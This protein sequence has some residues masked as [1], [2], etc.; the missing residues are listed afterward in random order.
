MATISKDGVNRCDEP[1]ISFIAQQVISVL[2]EQLLLN[3]PLNKEWFQRE[4]GEQIAAGRPIDMLLP[5]FPCKSINMV[6]SGDNE[7][8]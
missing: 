2:G 1:G 6:R 3:F 7:S 5:A 4:I 8:Q